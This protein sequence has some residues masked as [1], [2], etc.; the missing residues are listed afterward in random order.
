MTGRHA[1]P[2]DRF[3]AKIAAGPNCCWVWTGSHN[4][5]GY[6]QFRVDSQRTCGA[7]VFSHELHKG[8]VPDAL[9]V[10]HLCRV[11]DCVNPEHLEAVPPRVN[12]L[13]SENPAA[14][15]A[16]KTHCIRDHEFTPENTRINPTTGKRSCDACIRLNKLGDVDPAL[17]TTCQS[18]GKGPFHVVRALRCH[19]AVCPPSI[20]KRLHDIQ[21][22]AIK[23]NKRD[24]ARARRM[25]EKG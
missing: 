4:G 2:A 13:R 24:R 17:L 16:R 6:G 25:K 23:A 10:D 21:S 19:E 1:P 14:I 12:I 15:N 9:E 20:E 8:P 22:G 7:H 11:R 5:D 3:Y 18:C